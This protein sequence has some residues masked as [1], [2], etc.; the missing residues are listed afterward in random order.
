MA[1]PENWVRFAIEISDAQWEED[2]IR[3]FINLFQYQ[4]FDA[5]VVLSRI[6]ELAK[7]ADLSRDQM[8][9]D[10]RALITLHLTRGNKLSSIEKRL[11]EEGKKEFALLKARYQLV[12]KAKEAADLTLSRIAIA[13]AGLTCRILPQVVAHTAV[14]RSRMESL[15][16]D[17]PVCMMHNAFAGLIDETLPEESIKALV[18]AHR[19]Y[20][21]EFSRTINVKHRGMEAKEILDA[22]DSALQA[23]LASSFLTPSQK[24][25]YLLSFKLVD[26]NGKV[27]KAVQQAA[28][29]LR[30]L[31]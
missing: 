13:N 11:S 24:R 10:I 19:L 16:A 15:S 22:N 3:E 23:G 20:L 25:A 9:R 5:A 29:V 30:S 17:Y 14:T 6:F 31:I 4:G 21:L 1:M 26:G 12:D 8:L 18:D 2:E 28:T 7:K 27:N